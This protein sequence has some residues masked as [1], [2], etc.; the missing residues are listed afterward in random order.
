VLRISGAEKDFTDEAL[1]MVPGNWPAL[2]RGVAE[3]LE[4]DGP[5]PV[6]I[7]D[8]LG[9]VRVMDAAR[10]S[11]RHGEAVRLDPPA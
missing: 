8:V 2:Y 10:E 6:L 11:G 5:A 1:A 7:D 4:G 3:A 9:T